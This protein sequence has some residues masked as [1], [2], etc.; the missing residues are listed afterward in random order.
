MQSYNA[1]LNDMKFIIEDF[2]NSGAADTLFK[3]NDIGE[4]KRI[5]S[6]FGY[7]FFNY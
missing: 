7:K 4:I 3:Q 6:N 5:E 2:L 1:P